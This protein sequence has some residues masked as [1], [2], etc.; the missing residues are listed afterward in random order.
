M[1]RVLH[2]AF[3][4]ALF[5]PKHVETLDRFDMPLRYMGSEEYATFAQRLYAEE[6][7]IIRKLGLRMD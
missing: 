3:K 2:D 5:D 6:S 1:V 4:E 7:A